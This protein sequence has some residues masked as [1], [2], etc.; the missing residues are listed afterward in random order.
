MGLVHAAQEVPK[1]IVQE[2]TQARMGLAGE[3][4]WAEKSKE[5]TGFSAKD[6]SLKN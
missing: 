6:K 2:G 1:G 5:L 4:F 3:D